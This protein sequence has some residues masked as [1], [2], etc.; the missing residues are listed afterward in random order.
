VTAR[1]IP[2]QDIINASIGPQ[3]PLGL[4]H[5][6]VQVLQSER[7]DGNAMR[8]LVG[9]S[10]GLVA[11]DPDGGGRV[12]QLDGKRVTSIAPAGWR[13]LWAVVDGR[14]IWRDEGNGWRRVVSVC[15]LP[16]ADGSEA[17]VLADTR[18]NHERGVLV[19]T[20]EA[21]LA[22]VSEGDEIEM[23]D[24]FDRAPDRG[25]WFTPWGGPPAVRTIAESRDAVY[26]NVHV[27]GVLRTVDEGA[28]WEPTIDIE[29]DVHQVATSGDRVYAAGARGLSIS[30]DRGASWRLCTAVLH[31]TY[32]RAVAVC[33]RRLLLSAST[34]PG[35]G[36]RAAL[37]RSELDGNALE[38]CRAG[39]PEW[40]SGNIDSLCLDALPDGQLAAFGA[41]D[42]ELYASTDQGASWS[43]IATGLGQVR[44][45]LVL[46]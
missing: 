14:E 40:F 20:S 7:E 4:I 29:A 32:C 10:G 9:T 6:P 13:W 43:R 45:V 30:D 44:R 16:G 5:S 35:G 39:L 11:L 38:R 31:A 33:G 22:R 25:V 1:Q 3:S 8:I 12:S 46:P 37:Y 28:T 36:G 26:V 18:V 41:E 34:G 42:G 27:G 19:G 21:R 2:I 24:S 15:A 17:T 23:V